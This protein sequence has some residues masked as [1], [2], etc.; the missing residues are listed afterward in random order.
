MRPVARGSSCA[1]HLPVLASPSDPGTGKWW[2]PGERGQSTVEL[3]ALLPLLVVI[4]LACAQVLMAGAARELA[5]NAAEAG[6]IATLQGRDPEAAARDAI[7]G[8][9]GSRIEV[10]VRGGS[11]LVEV[12]PASLVPPLARLLVARAKA[13]AGS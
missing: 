5:G 11:V 10:E 3:V 13:H 8:W 4:G 2:G 7:P 1:R 12:E 6:A 9:T